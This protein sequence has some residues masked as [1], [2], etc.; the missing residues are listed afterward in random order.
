MIELARRR[1]T[2]KV[3]GLSRHGQPSFENHSRLRAPLA[4]Q[5]VQTQ[6]EQFSTADFLQRGVDGCKV[7]EWRRLDASAKRIAGTR[8]NMRKSKESEGIWQLSAR[9]EVH[10][11]TERSSLKS[12][13]NGSGKGSGKGKTG[14]GKTS[15]RTHASC[16][17]CGKAGHKNAECSFLERDVYE[18]RQSGSLESSEAKLPCTRGA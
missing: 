1:E 17:G 10:C 4:W 2:D 15:P 8:R 18:L 6:V 9:A 13:G 11:R 5:D 12:K 7:P 16:L 3:R 14:E